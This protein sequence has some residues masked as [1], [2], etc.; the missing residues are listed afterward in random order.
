MKVDLI[1]RNENF[2]CF[3]IHHGN[4]KEI[5]AEERKEIQRLITDSEKHGRW[6]V[7]NF[8]IMKNMPTVMD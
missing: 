7:K 5:M 8:G 6:F 1:L 3:K 2:Y 4:Q